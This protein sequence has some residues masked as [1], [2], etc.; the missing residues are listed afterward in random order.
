MYLVGGGGGYYAVD[1]QC[2][3]MCTA[4][5]RGGVQVLSLGSGCVHQGIVVHELLHALGLWHEQ[6]RYI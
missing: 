4:G 5:S 2:T 6:S 3:C 1:I